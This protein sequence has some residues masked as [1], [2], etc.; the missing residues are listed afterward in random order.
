MRRYLLIIITIV[1]CTTNLW[2]GKRRSSSNDAFADS[3]MRLVFHYAATVDTTGQ[4]SHSSYA[5]TKF[6]LRTNKRN[7]TLM[8]VPTMYAVAHGGNRKFICEYY[9]QLKL[10]KQGKPV[11]KRLLNLSTIPHRRSTMDQALRYLT[12]H[13]YGETLFQENILSPFHRSNRRYYTYSVTP[14]PFGMAQIYVYPRV[15]NTQ[16]VTAR[17]IVSSKTGKISLVDFEGE[18]DMTH[19]YISV[20]MGKEGFFSLGPEKCDMRA[21]FRFM[22]NRIS[23]MYTSVY[24]LSE[25]LS[26]TLRHVAD[27]AQ[28]ARVR[29][30]QLNQEEESIYKQYFI[31]RAKN[32]TLGNKPKNDFVKDVLWDVLGD[33]MLNRISSG[34]GSQNQGYFRMSPILNPLYMGYSGRKGLVYKFDVRSSYA[35]NRDLQLSL[36]FKGGYSMRQHRFYFKVP[37]VFNYNAKHEGY[38]SIEVGN[39]NRITSNRVARSMLGITER[40][41]STG[42]GAGMPLVPPGGFGQSPVKPELPSNAYGNDIYDFKDDYLRILNHWRFNQNFACEAGLVSHNRIAVRPTIYR[43]LGYPT[44]YTSVAPA[45]GLEWSPMGRKGP[46]LKLDYERG[47]KNFFKSNISYERWEFDAQAILYSSKRRSFSLRFGTGFYTRKGEHWDF[48]DYTNFH[49][50]N[51]PGGWNDSWSGEF[52]LLSSQWYNA[53]DYYLRSNFTYESPMIVVAWFPLIGRYI[54]KERIYVS[55]LSVKQLSPYTEWGYGI[56]TRLVTL[57]AFAAFKKGSFDGVG[58]RFGFELFSNW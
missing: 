7:A 34:F 25:P 46:V 43:A 1:F 53:S 41:D 42:I 10:D 35:F 36:Q 45:L 29:P 51:I 54:E 28:M 13:V 49:D 20:K 16:A 19:F 4:G 44:T 8:L 50:N 33:N 17:A 39:G 57:G 26:D 40:R 18:Y 9:S 48:V 14:L 15:K 22:G 52:E 37:L 6:Q 56:T 23:G 38:F 32:D 2:A 27:T 58:F 47:I 3:V 12:P 11:I 24:N 55:G 31:Q 30:I 21:N 5:Y